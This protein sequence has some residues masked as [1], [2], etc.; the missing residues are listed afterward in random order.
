MT[1]FSS[2][3]II[4]HRVLELCPAANLHSTRMHPATYTLVTKCVNKGS[5]FVS[6]TASSTSFRLRKNIVSICVLCKPL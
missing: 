4:I 2:F 6:K 1:Y 3:R 5:D